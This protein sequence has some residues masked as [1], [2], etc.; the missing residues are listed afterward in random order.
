MALGLPI[1]TAAVGQHA[2]QPDLV[3]LEQRRHPSLS[4]SAAVIGGVLRW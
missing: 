4:R 2:Q 1:L 3:L